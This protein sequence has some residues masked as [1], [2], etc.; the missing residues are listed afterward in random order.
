MGRTLRPCRD[1]FV[2]FGYFPDDQN[3]QVLATVCRALRPGGRLLVELQNQAR[4]LR[5][6]LPETTVERN[7]DWT[8]DRH[9]YDPLT[10]RTLQTRTVIRD[11]KTRTMR[12]FLPAYSGSPNSATGSSPPASHTWTATAPTV[13]R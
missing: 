5:Q 2:S 10:G 3:R 6:Y 4:L 7:G 11:G 13:S 12:Y 8:I 1:W 9:T